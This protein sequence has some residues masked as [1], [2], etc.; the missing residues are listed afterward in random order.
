MA[1]LLSL[2]SSDTVADPPLMFI[3]TYN[4]ANPD[5]KETIKNTGQIWEGLVPLEN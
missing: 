5:I 4:K 1:K 3:T 2:K